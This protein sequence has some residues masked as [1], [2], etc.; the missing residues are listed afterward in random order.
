[1]NISIMGLGKLGFPMSKFLSNHGH[2]V[3]C[4]DVNSKLSKSLIINHKGY[5]KSEVGIKKYKRKIK[6]LF[7][8]YECLLNTDITFVTVPTPSLNNGKFSNQFILDVLEKISYF[9]KKNP[10]KHPHIININSTVSPGSFENEL[11]PF[12]KNKGLVNNVDYSFL[13]N[14]YFVALGNVFENLENPDFVLLGYSSEY[15]LK[16]IKNIYKDIYKNL[17]IREMTLKEAELVKLLVN[18]YITAKISFTNFVKSITDK[19]GIKSANIILNAVGSDKRIGKSYFRQGAPFSGPCFPRDNR[20]LEIFCRTIKLNPLIP[21]TTNKINFNTYSSMFQILKF[22]KDKKINKI[23][24]LGAGYKSNTDSL[25]ESVALRLMK[26]SK[27]V[28]LKVYYY[29]KYLINNLLD[30]KRCSN[31]KKLILNSEVL[32]ISY[33]DKQFNNLDRYLLSKKKFVWDVFD[34]IRSNKIKKFSNIFQFKAYFE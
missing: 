10:K 3:S 20:A 9:I 7:S 17:N 18:C 16:K 15:S 14:P 27:K 23:G 21:S 4:F 34:I 5:L 1:M 31:I 6:I 30:Y 22:I 26:K 25:E 12:M 2:N 32:F 8:S 33:V 28:G 13:Y 24:F 11:I 19:T 29:D